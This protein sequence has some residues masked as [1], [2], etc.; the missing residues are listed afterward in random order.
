[1]HM[2]NDLVNAH[3]YI[4]RKCQ[5]CTRVFILSSTVLKRD[6]EIRTRY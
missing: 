4:Q 5:G 6:L 3:I 2:D 1:M